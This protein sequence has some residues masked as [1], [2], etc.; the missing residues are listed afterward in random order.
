MFIQPK[1]ASLFWL[2]IFNL[3][4]IGAATAYAVFIGNMEF[5]Y[6]VG[7]LCLMIFGTFIAHKNVHYSA[8]LLWGLSFWGLAHLAGGLITI[9]ETWPIDGGQRVLYSFWIIENRLKYDQLV[10]IYGFAVT[11][12]LAWQTLSGIIHRRYQRRL[13]PTF[14][15]LLIC[16]TSSMGFGAIN[17]VVEFFA[18]LMLPETNVGGYINTGWDL[19]SNSIGAILAAFTIKIRHL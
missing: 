5:L 2:F 11:T 6:Y 3:A 10:H 1:H 8:A 14:G 16:A 18:T 12:Y 17:E 13:H 9:P 19:V 7:I 15:L 4:Y